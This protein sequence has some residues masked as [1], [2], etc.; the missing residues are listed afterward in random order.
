MFYKYE[1]LNLVNGNVFN[2]AEYGLFHAVD[3]ICKK[4]QAD[5]DS[6]DSHNILS[7]EDLLVLYD[8]ERIYKEN[9]LGFMK[10]VIFDLALATIWRPG[11]LYNL[12]ISDLKKVKKGEEWVYEVR[13]R[14]GSQPGASKTEQGGLKAVND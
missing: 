5:G 8:S 2:N 10:W 14:I 4:V 12:Q 9:P 13:S 6:S 1:N 7:T 3:N 11:Q